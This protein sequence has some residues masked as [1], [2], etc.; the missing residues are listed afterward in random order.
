MPFH[1]RLWYTLP[2]RDRELVKHAYWQALDDAINERHG[3]QRPRA[4]VEQLDK[5]G[6]L[7]EQQHHRDR[8]DHA[9]SEKT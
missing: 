6:L 2:E 5:D 9:N 7:G 4:L 3:K 8:R 1:T